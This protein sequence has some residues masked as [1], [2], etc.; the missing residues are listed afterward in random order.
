MEADFHLIT[1]GQQV[2]LVPYGEEGE[3]LRRDILQLAERHI[4]PGRELYRRLQRIS[5][6]IYA[7]E[8]DQLHPHLE[9]LHPDADIRMLSTPALY[10]ELTGLQRSSKPLPAES[11][12]C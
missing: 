7:A 8:Y 9:T 4:M 1:P 2:I 3:Q 10:S 5:V 11:L 12:I 6:S